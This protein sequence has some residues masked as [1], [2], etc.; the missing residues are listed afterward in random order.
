MGACVRSTACFASRKSSSGFVRICS[1]FR[2]TLTAFTGA[3]PL[4][5]FRREIG[6]KRSRLERGDPRRL[7]G[8]NHVRGGAALKHLAHEN[9]LPVFV[10]IGDAIADH[11]LS[12]AT[13]PASARNRGPG[14]CAGARTRSGF[15]ASTTWRSASEKPSGVYCREQVMLDEEHFVELVAG[16]FVGERGHAFADQ[17]RRKAILWPAARSAAPLRASQS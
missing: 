6:A 4:G 1:G 9:Q 16:K 14:T 17:R 13:P 2:S 3:F 11:S 5:M 10:A 12:A 15:A 7:A 8:E